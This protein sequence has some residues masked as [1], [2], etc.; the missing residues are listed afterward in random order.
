MKCLGF[1]LFSPYY[2]K[3]VVL[4][5]FSYQIAPHPL[6]SIRSFTPTSFTYSPTPLQLLLWL[7]YCIFS[8]TSLTFP[9]SV[10]DSD[11]CFSAPIP[12]FFF[13]KKLRPF[14]LWE[15]NLLCL[16]FLGL[17]GWSS[18]PWWTQFIHLVS[19][20]FSISYVPGSKDTGLEWQGSCFL[21]IYICIRAFRDWRLCF[22]IFQPLATSILHGTQYIPPKI[23]LRNNE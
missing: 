6:R 1:P 12:L 7:S 20:F 10:E 11:F 4:V 16:C 15:Q 17:L 5:F 2:N 23:W 14:L 8:Q 13:L 19:L 9:V 22:Y 3:C 21:R 18:G